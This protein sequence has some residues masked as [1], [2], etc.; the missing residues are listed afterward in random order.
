MPVIGTGGD[1]ARGLVNGRV[2]QQQLSNVKTNR[3]ENR[4]E[5]EDSGVVLTTSASDTAA[6]ARNKEIERL[7]EDSE[8][9]RRQYEKWER[10]MGSDKGVDGP[11][12]QRVQ[13]FRRD[14]GS[15]VGVEEHEKE[16]YSQVRG[17]EKTRNVRFTEYKP[18]AEEV[19]YEEQL[20]ENL[21]KND[22]RFEMVFDLK[23]CMFCKFNPLP[24][25][26][27]F[28]LIRTGGS[29]LILYFPRDPLII[30]TW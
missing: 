6:V 18:M 15:S 17:E 9:L 29:A 27:L 30:G 16:N 20:E 25:F 24:P 28:L 2:R 4:A 26:F 3:R 19:K 5:D 22:F 13:V 23:V 10:R 11:R 8:R 21:D 1:D 7:R 14:G 12:A